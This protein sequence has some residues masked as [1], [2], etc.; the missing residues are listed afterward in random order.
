MACQH[1]KFF[2]VFVDQIKSNKNVLQ[3]T[4]KIETV[5]DHCAVQYQTKI[6]IKSKCKQ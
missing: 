2:V 1:N 4:I 3:S 5:V 6:N